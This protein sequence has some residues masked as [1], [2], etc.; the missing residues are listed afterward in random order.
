MRVWRRP[1]T[2]YPRRRR[3]RRRR[4]SQEEEEAKEEEEERS[5]EEEEPQESQEEE[6]EPRGGGKGSREPINSRNLEPSKGQCDTRRR[7]PCA[8]R[9]GSK[10]CILQRRISHVKSL[11]ENTTAVHHG[12]SRA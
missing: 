1:S 9:R 8:R 5:Q 7:A 11:Y 6:A 3:R 12:C 10:T 4:R 2:L